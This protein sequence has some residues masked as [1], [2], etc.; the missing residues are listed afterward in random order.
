MVFIFISQSEGTNSRSQR[1]TGSSH[2]AGTEHTTRNRLTAV[3]ASRGDVRLYSY[4]A[5]RLIQFSPRAAYSTRRS[6]S[7]LFRRRVWGS[8]SKTNTPLPSLPYKLE[9]ICVFENHQN[10]TY[11]YL[12]GACFGCIFCKMHCKFYQLF[13]WERWFRDARDIFFVCQAFWFYQP[14]S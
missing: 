9:F 8:S 3:S 14:N 2:T 4:Y 1:E 13:R 10:Q 12:V 6:K 5:E 11:R 7:L